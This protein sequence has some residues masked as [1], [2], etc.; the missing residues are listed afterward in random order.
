MQE[1]SKREA[2]DPILIQWT[3][4]NTILID[5]RTTSVRRLDTILAPHT[6]ACACFGG[7]YRGKDTAIFEGEERER[8]R[9]NDNG[10]RLVSEQGANGTF[11]IG[12][13]CNKREVAVCIACRMPF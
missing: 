12:P 13:T 3:M 9:V 11:R 1:S 6:L 10:P 2:S 8:E 5:S 4:Q 7:L